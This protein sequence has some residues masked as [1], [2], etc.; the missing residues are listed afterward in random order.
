MNTIEFRGYT[1]ENDFEK[2]Q[3]IIAGVVN[4]ICSDFIDCKVSNKIYKCMEL[5]IKLHK[6][7]NRFDNRELYTQI[8]Y[9][10]S[11]INEILSFGRYEY[12]LKFKN[13]KNIQYYF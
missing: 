9:R 5:S 2:K 13:I 1:L 6:L 7:I 8:G 10:S 11:F 3:I 4:K 12:S